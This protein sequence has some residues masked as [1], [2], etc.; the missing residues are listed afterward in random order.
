MGEEVIK[1]RRGRP[2]GSKNQKPF[3]VMSDPKKGEPLIKDGFPN[4]P[5]VQLM[6]RPLGAKDQLPRQS[7]RSVEE[8][9]AY[10]DFMRS[11]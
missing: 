8:N 11:R 10:L 7:V 4:L 6:G 2:L 5:V 3:P 1:R 9:E